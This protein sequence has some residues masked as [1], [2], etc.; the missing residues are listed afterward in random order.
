[1]QG[2]RER[3]PSKTLKAIAES[4]NDYLVKVKTNQP[5]LYQQIE[6]ESSQ[7]IAT[8]TV[9]DHE[10]TRDRN[11]CRKIEVFEPP[12]TLDPK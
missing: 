4:G 11:S 6:A 12:E 9:E 3:A 8:Q 5:K 10:K 2:A 7:Q 1:M